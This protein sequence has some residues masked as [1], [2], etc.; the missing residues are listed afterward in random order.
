MAPTRRSVVAGV[1]AIVPA[2]ALAVSEPGRFADVTCVRRDVGNVQL[3]WTTR[4]A[5]LVTAIQSSTD[6]DG[7]FSTHLGA[8]R[9]GAWT[10]AALHRLAVAINVVYVIIFIAT[11]PGCAL[12]TM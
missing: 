1:L 3:Q 9:D 8:S 5:H 4:P 6:P 11:A 12:A 10:G 2:T 7:P